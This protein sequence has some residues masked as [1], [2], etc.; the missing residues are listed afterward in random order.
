MTQYS[1]DLYSGNAPPARLAGATQGGQQIHT[2]SIQQNGK[3]PTA[4]ASAVFS[5]TVT[6]TGGKTLT[7]NGTTVSGGI[8]KFSVPRT[9]SCFCSSNAS[10]HSFTIA[11]YDF[12]GAT[13]SAN[14]TGPNNTT[15]ET[16]KAF[17]QVTSI[18]YNAGASIATKFKIGTGTSFGFNKR[19]SDAGK[20]LGVFGNG[21][22]ETTLTLVAAA[23]ASVVSTATTAD[24]R[25]TYKPNTSPNGSIYFTSQLLV[26]AD[27]MANLYGNTQA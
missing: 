6:A 10:G 13:M 22:P 3:I 26:T 23:L 7:L 5:N 12:Y 19:M 11:G 9:V 18:T 4:L 14:L 21:K 24:V 15:V 2:V 27:P 17:M 1:D 20:C 25:G 16:V 8:A